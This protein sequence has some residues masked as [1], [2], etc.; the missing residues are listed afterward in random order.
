MQRVRC[1]SC[2]ALFRDLRVARCISSEWNK[3]NNFL[4]SD[5]IA[6]QYSFHCYIYFIKSPLSELDQ[7]CMFPLLIVNFSFKINNRWVV[8]VC[9]FN[10]VNTLIVYGYMGSLL[11]IYKCIPFLR[12]EHHFKKSFELILL[13]LLPFRIW[14]FC[15]I[16]CTQKVKHH[17]NMSEYFCSKFYIKR[18]S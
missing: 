17:Q 3:K 18:S 15:N 14:V 16:Y 9:V 8:N 13:T 6:P 4:L 7:V 11:F 12:W 1:K 10:Y 2:E 5:K